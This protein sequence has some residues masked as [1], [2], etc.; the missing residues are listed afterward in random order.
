[1]NENE[2]KLAQLVSSLGNTADEIAGNLHK[3]GILGKQFCD[4]D[5]P[6]SNFLKMHGYVFP[7]VY[8][9][10]TVTFPSE[11]APDDNM[12][13]IDNPPQLSDFIHNF[14]E[15][16]YPDLMEKVDGKVGTWRVT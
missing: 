15:G 1:M 12:I 16:M 11:D 6:A 5:C 3:M 8:L 14:D 9:S 2:L 13:E 7:S 4:E 10:Q